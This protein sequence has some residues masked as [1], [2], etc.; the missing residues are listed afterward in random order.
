[1]IKSYSEIIR[2]IIT[3]YYTRPQTQQ[4]PRESPETFVTHKPLQGI[5]RIKDS[6]NQVVEMA[7]MGLVGIQSPMETKLETTGLE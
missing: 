3:G 5:G 2:R 4:V 6:P 7:R 1:M